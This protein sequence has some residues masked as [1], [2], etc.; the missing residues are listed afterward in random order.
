MKCDCQQRLIRNTT[1]V[2]IVLNIV[3]PRVATMLAT[4]QEVKPPGGAARLD[5]KGQ[6]MHML[7]HHAQVP[8]SSSI[9][10]ALIVAVSLSVALRLK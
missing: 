6:I 2:A 10:V 4:R 1:I 9:V 3:L 7:V 5:L 8:V